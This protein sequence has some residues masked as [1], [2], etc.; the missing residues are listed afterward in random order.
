VVIFGV[1]DG[2]KDEVVDFNR[3]YSLASF[4]GGLGGDQTKPFI[5]SKPDVPINGGEITEAT[6]LHD[7][8]EKYKEFLKD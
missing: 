5:I 7:I 4:H 1:Y 3:K 8:H 6:Q 2:D